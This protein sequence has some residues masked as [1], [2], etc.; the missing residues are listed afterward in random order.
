MKLWE[1]KIDKNIHQMVNKNSTMKRK[2]T[3]VLCGELMAGNKLNADMQ[4]K[5]PL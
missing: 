4:F 1:Y 3:F 2:K 5:S